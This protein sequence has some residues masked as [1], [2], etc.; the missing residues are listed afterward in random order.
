MSQVTRAALKAYFETGDTPTELQYIDLIDS[1]LN[2]IDNA[3][4][5]FDGQA[6]GGNHVQTFSASTTFD[7]DNGNNQYMEV[8]GSTTIAIT[9]ELPGTYL[10]RLEINSTSNPTITIGASFGDPYDNS[11]DLIDE[12]ND[13]NLITLVVDPNGVK[14]YTINTK[15]A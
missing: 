2:I 12:D 11:A 3:N 14:E 1:L 13:V 7:A 4:Y 9:N 15:T 6:H 10:F 5:S 8:T